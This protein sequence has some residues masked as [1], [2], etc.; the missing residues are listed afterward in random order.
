MP[1][2][3]A[4][5]WPATAVL[6]PRA[7]T[8]VKSRFGFT[9]LELVIVIGL[10]GALSMLVLPRLRVTK[11]WA[12]DESLAPSEMMEIRR[13][14]AAFQA[15]CLPSADDKDQ[16]AQ[17][18]LAI[19]M[20]TNVAWS[21]AWSFPLSYEPNRGKG[22][23][24]PYLQPEGNRTIYW[25]VAGQPTTGTGPTVSI[26]VI[27]DPRHD[28]DAAS[29]GDHYYRVL[30][31]ANQLHLVYVGEDGTLGTGDDVEQPLETP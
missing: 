31:R 23:R 30:L 25:S 4:P 11:T 13:A 17:Y 14:Y 20:T 27:H 1:T 7:K 19:L 24:G 29:T 6:S 8:S 26:P 5:W 3:A 15:D 16:I 10:L 22:W 18:G 9:L 2:A 21:S 12:V 28:R